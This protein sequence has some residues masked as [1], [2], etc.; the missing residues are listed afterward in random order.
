MTATDM[1]AEECADDL[2]FER[3]FEHPTEVPACKDCHHCTS[4]NRSIAECK[5]PLVATDP[6]DGSLAPQPWAHV[7]AENGL[8]GLFGGLWEPIK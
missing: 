5:H 1:T 6:F 2:G 3:S 8:C 4:P 7:R